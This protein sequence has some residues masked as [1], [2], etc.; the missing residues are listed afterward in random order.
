MNGTGRRN[1]NVRKRG[2]QEMRRTR[3]KEMKD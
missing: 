3:Q 1:K 2:G